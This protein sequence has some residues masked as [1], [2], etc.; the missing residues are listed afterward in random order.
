M[1]KLKLRIEQL[2][3]TVSLPPPMYYR[4]GQTMEEAKEKYLHQ[5][6]FNLPTDAT[7]VKYVRIITEANIG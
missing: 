3:R 2:E 5:H 7:V 6:G 1:A 4:S